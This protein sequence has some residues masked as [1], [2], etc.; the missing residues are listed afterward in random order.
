MAAAPRRTL[1]GTVN[2][3]TS[4]SR[5]YRTADAVEVDEVEG[6]DVTR[7]RV[8]LDEILL[9]THHRERGTAFVVSA[10]GLFL[11][12]GA[13]SVLVATADRDAAFLVF[14]FTALPALVALVWRLLRGVDV[15]TVFGKRT[16][17]ALRFPLRRARAREVFRLVCRL[18]R[19]AQA[20]RGGAR[21][22]PRPGAAG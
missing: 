9:V 10:L 16:R 3:V 1:L 21:A 12:C 13:L 2:G 15:V 7:R 6:T 17:A 4:A 22:S 20:T 19:E 14:G 18:A 8:L 11:A 5:V